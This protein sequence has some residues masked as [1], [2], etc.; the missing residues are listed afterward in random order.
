MQVCSLVRLKHRIAFVMNIAVW[1]HMAFSKDICMKL[2]AKL[3]RNP[4]ASPGSEGLLINAALIYWLFKNKTERLW[5]REV[6]KMQKWGTAQA[7]HINTNYFF[8]KEK[9]NPYTWDWTYCDLI[10]FLKNN[11]NKNA[12]EGE[13]DIQN[14]SEESHFSLVLVCAHQVAEC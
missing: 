6:N 3:T 4:L 10:L 12:V 5:E 8:L 13:R 1:F 2:N 9:R 14:P 7:F 11:N